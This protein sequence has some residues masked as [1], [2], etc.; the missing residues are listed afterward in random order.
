MET[1]ATLDYQ[2]TY[3]RIKNRQSFSFL[4]TREEL[5][6]QDIE[7]RIKDVDFRLPFDLPIFNSLED[8]ITLLLR[9]SIGQINVNL[10][11]RIKML[12]T[13]FDGKILYQ[14]IEDGKIWEVI[15]V[16]PVII[17]E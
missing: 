10:I 17:K 11:N 5:S 1:L 8:I 4:A 14:K 3:E 6:F 7:R 15:I 13:V 2:K 9:D 16:F 12:V